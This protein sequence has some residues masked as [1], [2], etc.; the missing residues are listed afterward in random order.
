[1][2]VEIKKEDVIRLMLQYCKENGMNKTFKC[3]QEETKVGLNSAE[4]AE[5]ILGNIINGK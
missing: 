4:H 1:M 5:S 2:T 3:M